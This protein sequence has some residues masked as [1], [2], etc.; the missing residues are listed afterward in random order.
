VVEQVDF[1]LQSTDVVDRVRL[2]RDQNVDTLIC[3][4][5]QER[6]EDMLLTDGVHVISWVSGRVDD[7]LDRFM[8]GELSPDPRLPETAKKGIESTSRG[9]R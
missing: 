4:G 9:G 8:R 2:M 5:L 7:L 1:C 6:L 3:G